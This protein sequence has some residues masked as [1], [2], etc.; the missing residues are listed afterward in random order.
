MSATDKTSTIT[1]KTIAI[2][3]VNAQQLHSWN[4]SAKI[5]KH[6]SFKRESMQPVAWEGRSTWDCPPTFLG[7]HPHFS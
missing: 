2:Y 7:I 1:Y 5:D 6:L 4:N 3:R